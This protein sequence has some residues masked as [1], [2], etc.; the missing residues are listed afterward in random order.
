MISFAK[1]TPK[2]LVSFKYDDHAR[3]VHLQSIDYR[4]DNRFMLKGLDYSVGDEDNWRTFNSE[5]VT[6]LELI[7]SDVGVVEKYLHNKKDDVET[8]TFDNQM[9]VYRKKFKP[10]V[11]VLDK[12]VLQVKFLHDSET[13]LLSVDG[14]DI[15]LE[16]L[17]EE[18]LKL[19]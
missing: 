13:V 18:F 9:V 3:L 1:L 17:Y 16:D 4:G 6:D 12:H 7:D 5:K 19:A 10:D 2:D 11:L 8:Y 14:K 15:K